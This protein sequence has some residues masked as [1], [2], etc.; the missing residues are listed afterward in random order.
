MASRGVSWGN[1]LRG[2]GALGTRLSR[3][4]WLLGGGDLRAEYRPPRLRGDPFGVRARMR[5]DR[6]VSA[7]GLGERCRQV[8][9]SRP[10]RASLRLGGGLSDGDG[11]HRRSLQVAALKLGELVGARG[12]AGVRV[13]PAADLGRTP[14]TWT[15]RAAERGACLRR[16]SR[17][18]E[19]IVVACAAH[20]PSLG[21]G[22]G[23]ERPPSPLPLDPV[24]IR[25]AM[26]QLRAS[27]SG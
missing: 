26:T 25:V 3:G 2:R 1:G 27:G 9:R 8:Q 17:L 23:A 13:W 24:E 19:S 22:D 18:D 14:R 20:H 10:L 16:A 21:S 7:A 5:G 4:R 12:G 15:R 6:R 11:L